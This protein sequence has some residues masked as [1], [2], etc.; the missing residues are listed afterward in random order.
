MKRLL[1]SAFREAW[2]QVPF[3]LCNGFRQGYRD[4]A[5]GFVLVLLVL[6]GFPGIDG[7]LPPGYPIIV[8]SQRNLLP[9]G[10]ASN[11]L[12][13]GRGFQHSGLHL[14][15]DTTPGVL[16]LRPEMRRRFSYSGPLFSSEAS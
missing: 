3:P 1:V 9:R 4:D 15:C 14:I 13:S 8:V 5:I 12:R 16:A 2:F 7:T 6:P 11:R 10:L